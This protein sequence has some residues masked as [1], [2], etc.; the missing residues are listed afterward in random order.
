MTDTI[1]ERVAK[2]ETTT[3]NL[4][5][6]VDKEHKEQQEYRDKVHD[7]LSGISNLIK[8]ESLTY[9]EEINRLDMK[10]VSLDHTYEQ[11]EQVLIEFKSFINEATKIF[12]NLNDFVVKQSTKQDDYDYMLEQSKKY[13]DYMLKQATRK[14]FVKQVFMYMCG[15]ATITGAVIAM[16]KFK[17]LG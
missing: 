16:L 9:K 10:M 4:K 7:R 13:D 2:L 1:N 6:E 8:L 5:K 15:F 11:Q 3:E 17:S 12:Q 14:A